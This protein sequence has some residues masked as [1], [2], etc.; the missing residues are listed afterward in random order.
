[1]RRGE[2]SGT[3]SATLGTGGF[4]PILGGQV[5][6]RLTGAIILVALMVLLVPELLTGPIRSAPRAAALATAAGGAP[7]RSYTIDLAEENHSRSAAASAGG[8][9]QPT[10][11]ATAPQAESGSAEAQGVPSTPLSTAA[12]SG[13]TTQPNPAASGS[14]GA[15]AGSTG[16]HTAARASYAGASSAGTEAAAGGA[17]A[18][19]AGASGAW[20]VQ[21]GSFAS[22]DNADR[23][24]QQVRSQG[25][26]VS[27]SQSSSGRHLYRVRVGAAHDRAAAVALAARLRALGHTG[28][29]EPRQSGT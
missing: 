14:A 22:R 23:L 2:L 18:S 4:G 1:V 26:A 5:K 8:P 24:A 9:Q 15:G 12:T 20:V 28:T 21:L 27:V 3:A 19:A 16:G 17:R 11:L 13:A 25:F 29:V 10:P 7:L 6:E